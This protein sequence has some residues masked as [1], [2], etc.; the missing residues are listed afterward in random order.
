MPKFRVFSSDNIELA[1][2]NSDRAHSLVKKNKAHFEIT[3]DQ[4]TILVVNKS[5]EQIIV[6]E[7]TDNEQR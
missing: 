1:P 6:K 5:S 4:E 3:I 7:D 2:C